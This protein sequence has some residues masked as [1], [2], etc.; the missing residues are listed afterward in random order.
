MQQNKEKGTGQ[1]IDQQAQVKRPGRIEALIEKLNAER[2]GDEIRSIVDLKKRLRAEEATLSELEAEDR[3]LVNAFDNLTRVFSPSVAEALISSDL[4]DRTAVIESKDKVIEKTLREAGVGRAD[5]GRAMRLIKNLRNRKKDVDSINEISVAIPDLTDSQIASLRSHGVET[6]E[7]W[8]DRRPAGVGDEEAARIDAHAR[9]SVVYTRNDISATLVEKAGISSLF[10]LASLEPEALAKLAKKLE[11]KK[12]ELLYAASEAR[13]RTRANRNGLIQAKAA[14]PAGPDMGNRPGGINDAEIDWSDFIKECEPCPPGVSVFSCFAYLVYLIQLT[15]ES[16]D[17]LRGKLSLN[18]LALDAESLLEASDN[19]QID[20]ET[21]TVCQ[22]AV[23]EVQDYLDQKRQ[24]SQLEEEYQRYRY[25]DF[26]AW[27]SLKMASLYPELHALWRGDVLTGE[28]GTPAHGSFLKDPVNAR[29]HLAT[30]LTRVREALATARVYYIPSDEFDYA[31]FPTPQDYEDAPLFSVAHADHHARFVEGLDVIDSILA[32]DATVAKAVQGLEID[33]PGNAQFELLQASASLDR[34]VEMTFANTSPWRTLSDQG[35]PYQALIDLHPRRR[36]DTMQ[37]LFNEMAY[38]EKPLFNPTNAGIK[39]EGLDE[40]GQISLD[41]T[42]IVSGAMRESSGQLEQYGRSSTESFAKYVGISAGNPDF[43]SFKNYDLSTDLTLTETLQD[44]DRLGIAAR[45]GTSRNTIVPR[46]GYMLAITQSSNT[47]DGGGFFEDGLGD[48]FEDLLGEEDSTYTRQHLHLYKITEASNGTV[49]YEDL[50]PPLLIGTLSAGGGALVVL[51]EDRRLMRTDHVYP[52][53]LSVI[54]NRITGELR[55]SE[56][57]DAL[58]ISAED[59]TYPSGTLGFFSQSGPRFTFSNTFVDLE[60]GVGLPPFYSRRR[61][62]NRHTLETQQYTDH[63]VDGVGMAVLDVSELELTYRATRRLVREMVGI[64]QVGTDKYLGLLYETNADV[65]HVNYLDDLLEDCLTGAFYLRYAVIPEMLARAHAL[66]GNY[67]SAID[68]LR[69]I[70]DDHNNNEY[71]RNVYPYLNQTGNI[72][73]AVAGA[74]Q[75]LMRIRIGENL[76]NQAEQLF[77]QD[78]DTSRYE[79]RQLYERVLALHFRSNQC[80]CEAKLG[81]VVETVLKNVVDLT[82]IRIKPAIVDLIFLIQE[83]GAS[84]DGIDYASLIDQHLARR[85]TADSFPQAVEALRRDI[86]AARHSHRRQIAQHSS[87]EKLEQRSRALM[88]EAEIRTIPSEADHSQRRF[89]AID[90]VRYDIA[91]NYPFIPLVT[92]IDLSFCIPE[93]PL[94]TQQVKQACLMLELIDS[95][96]NILGFPKQFVPAQRFSFLYNLAEGMAQAAH[97]AEQDV[98]RFRGMLESDTEALINAESNLAISV[99]TTALEAQNVQLAMGDVELAG[100]QKQ[101][102]EFSRDHFQG[103]VDNGLSSYEQL[104]LMAAGATVLFSGI[105]AAGGILSAAATAAGAGATAT[106]N[107]AGVGVAA[108]GIAGTVLGGAQG[109]AGFSSSISGF[110]SMQAGFQRR[111][112][113]WRYNLGLNEI[114]VSIANQSVQQAFARLDIAMRQ[115]QIATMRQESAA[116]VVSFLKHR[117]LNREM[118]TWLLRTSREQYRTRLNYAIATSFMAERALAFELML[119]QIDAVRF[120][121]FEPQRDGL[122]GSSQLITDLKGLQVTRVNSD[123]RRLQL[124]RTFSLAELLP[125]EL[126]TFKSTGV[127]SFSTLMDW[128][129]RDFPGH[130]QRLI[131]HV[132]VSM[133]ALVPPHQGVKA[134]LRNSGVSRVVVGPPVASAFESKTVAR[135]PQAVALT[136]AIDA[137]GILQLNYQDEFLLPFEGLGVETDWLLEMPAASNPFDYSTIADVYVTIDYTA[138]HNDVYAGMVRQALGNTEHRDLSMHFRTQYPDEW[139]HLHNDPVDSDGNKI[140]DVSLSPEN[141]PQEFDASQGISVRH[142][143]VLLAGDFKTLNAA[144]KTRLLDALTIRHVHPQGELVL[145]TAAGAGITPFEI[146]ELRANDSIALFSTRDVTDFSSDLGAGI[147]PQGEWRL[148]LN[149]ALD[150]SAD[151]KSLAGLLEDVLL[152]ISLSGQVDRGGSVIGG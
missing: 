62:T 123:T 81:D 52:M 39:V 97:S 105:G 84:D 65:I 28:V 144:Q 87:L 61:P 134:M 146:A 103:L 1:S 78:T 42:W 131:R 38:G 68:H 71:F 20:C 141:L 106:G 119:P 108:V 50:K 147:S 36:R 58:V 120:D 130:Y 94:I 12:S 75:T 74:D 115:Q 64:P 66:A 59:P 92:T 63:R 127:L 149:D 83:V 118:L 117:F 23:R 47:V 86:E 11:L 95:C 24:S 151:P 129:D 3:E 99:A 26:A 41:S 137:N 43:A 100:L 70:Y 25:L 104:A 145:G 34:M 113:E 16:L 8:A 82:D 49:Q 79:A 132:S 98:L 142:V 143:A 14:A 110:A 60:G 139:Y 54:G 138:L 67:Q 76:L 32:A 128:F 140:M 53:K 55:V 114:G 56:D 112:Q 124:R 85:L 4:I 116:D 125:A 5:M 111:E 69:V 57:S 13:A 136:S 150:N 90:R 17:T 80:D 46:T 40:N 102:A 101:Q 18:G 37:A 30:Q 73:Q 126:Q 152:I 51:D 19:P 35:S 29:A 15:G 93:N 10:E 44:G 122:L 133:L 109:L 72:F 77:R 107:P 27:K 148:V 88:E 121:Y 22:Q 96:R 48:F 7:D 21:I 45:W 91:L 6:I 9:L 2:E 31:Q 89:D 33:D 135:A